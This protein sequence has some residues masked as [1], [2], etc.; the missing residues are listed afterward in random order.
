MAI[1]YGGLVDAMRALKDFF[2]ANIDSALVDDYE[3]EAIMATIVASAEVHS[4]SESE[5]GEVLGM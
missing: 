3:Q 2:D 1:G 5:Q 4:T